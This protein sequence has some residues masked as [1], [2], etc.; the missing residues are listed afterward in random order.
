MDF[1]FVFDLSLVLSVDESITPMASLYGEGGGRTAPGNTLQGG[2]F[3]LKLICLLFVAEF[4]ND[5]ER[6]EWRGDDIY[7]RSL[8]SEA[9]TK[10]GHQIFQE[11][12][13]KIG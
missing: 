7:K 3:D 9:M 1:N 11:K 6:W 13:R 4:R 2:E 12:N 8:L 5:V 10:K